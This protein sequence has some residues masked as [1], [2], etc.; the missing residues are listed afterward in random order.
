MAASF[1]DFSKTLMDE[2]LS[3][4]PLYATQLGWHK[5]DKSMRDVSRQAVEQQAMRCTQLI[6]ELKR[7]PPDSL[8]PAERVD[9]DLA[10]HLLRLWLYEVKELKMHERVSSAAT[11]IGNALFPLMI[12]EHPSFDDRLEAIIAR[13]EAVPQFLERSRNVLRA[14]NRVWNEEAYEAGKEIPALLRGIEALVVA[15]PLTPDRRDRLTR[16][17]K[18]AADELEKHNNWLKVTI[19]PKASP[20]YALTPSEYATYI[21]MKGYGVNPD[22]AL[23]IG[24]VYLDLAKRKMRETVKEILPGG[25]LTKALEMMK[26]DRPRSF[27]EAFK[28]YKDA[29]RRCRD[30][31]IK[32]NLLTVPSGEDLVVLET[33]EFMRPIIPFQTQLEP[34]KFDMNRTGLFLVT[35]TGDNTE[36]LKEHAFST[37][38]NSAV[39]EGYPG[40]HVQ[41]ICSRSNTSYIRALCFSPDYIEGWGLYVEDL[42]LQQG[43]NSTPM[44]RLANLNDLIYRIVRLIAEIKLSK[45]FLTL[46][47]AAELFRKECGIE[48]T[49]AKIEARSC[50]M[51]PAYYSAYL[52]GKL[53]IMQLREEVQVA[54]AEKY[55]LKAFHDMFLYSGCMPV[56]LMR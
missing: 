49:S 10:E 41:S 40:H 38:A 44:G 36:L 15:K 54:M 53:A 39:H 37:M 21:S 23:R 51:F 8:T 45:G 26:S 13:L 16:A 31:V 42:M 55:S 17:M 20:R 5:Y 48:I 12:R 22:E 27:D 4:D 7:Y 2:Y 52:I 46:D 1:L 28:E 19:I 24:D 50:A 32:S 29:V 33:P 25:D 18:K 11:D 43:F 35:P 14:P 3:W 34:G 6:E 56:K 9:R 47:S 30:F